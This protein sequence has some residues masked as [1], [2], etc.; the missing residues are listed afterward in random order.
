MG[1]SDNS[2][3]T[4]GFVICFLPFYAWKNRQGIVKYIFVLWSFAAGMLISSRLMH[5]EAASNPLERYSWG[6]ML[7]IAYDKPETVL[8]LF[9]I[10][11]AAA[12]AALLIYLKTVK[13]KEKGTRRITPLPR[14]I[15]LAMGI[16][17]SAAVV[18]IF[19]D[20]N[21]GGHPELWGPYSNFLVFNDAWGTH[22]GYNWRLLFRHFNDFSLFKKLVGSGPETYGI[23][24]RVHDYYEMSGT[25]DEIYDSPHN[26]F[27]QYMFNTGILGAIG[28]YGLIVSSAVTAFTRKHA[29]SIVPAAAFAILA[30]T[31][32]SVV[33]I[34]APIVMPLV[35]LFTAVCLADRSGECEN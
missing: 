2:L 10:M 25:F 27:L 20:A 32:Q 3:L 28:Y 18:Y 6:E 26:E 5:T 15:W 11:T 8:K 35:M 23:Y 29:D 22:R 30:Y 21:H 7:V 1:R 31:F 17:A 13:D 16:I 19:Y 34:S 4:V 33:N 9:V 12:L 24:T 14:L